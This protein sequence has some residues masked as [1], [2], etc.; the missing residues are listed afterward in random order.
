MAA[1]ASALRAGSPT[2]QARR[3][4]ARPRPS[5][6]LGRAPTRPPFLL[7]RA[8]SQRARAAD[9]R[10][11]GS[12]RLRAA[13]PPAMPRRKAQPGGLPRAGAASGGQAVLSRFFR[14]TGSLKCDS[15]PAG[16]AETADAGSTHSPSLQ[17]PLPP[18]GA[19]EIDRRKRRSSES[20]GP[21]KKKAKKLQDLEGGSDSVVSGRSEPKKCLRTRI[22]LQSLEKL[23]EFCCD[24][25]LPPHRA[26]AELPEKRFAVLPKCTDFEDISLQYKKSAV[27]LEDSSSQPNQKDAQFGPSQRSHENLQR[28]LDSRAP[29][30]RSKS[31]YTPLELQYLDVKRQHGDAVLCVECGYKYRFFGEDA[32]I[33]ARELNICCHLDHNFMTASIPTHRLFV[34]VRR[35]V[36]KGYKVG[37]V[38]Q[39]ETAALKALGDTR[40]SVF[41]R[42]LTALYTKSTLIGEDVNPL[43]QLD[44]A[45]SVDEPV[46]DTSSGF[47]LC[48]CESKESGTDG[49]SGHVLIG[50]VGVQPAT[51]EV[52]TDSFQD[53]AS[54]TELET[55]LSSLQPAELLLPTDLSQPTESLVHRTTLAGV[56]DDRIRVERM[57]NIYF[58]YSHAFQVVT[59]FYAKD[60]VDLK[61]SQSF[62]GIINLEKPVLCSLAALIRYLKEFNLEKV[63]SKPENFTQLSSEMEFMTL[64]GTTL[65]NLEILQNQTD[66]KTKGSL[67]WVLDHT[68]TSF[69]RRKLKKWVTQPLLKLR[70]I[71]AR[72][73]AVSE[74]LKS[75]ASVFGQ[76]ESQLHRL[77]DLERG[78][79]SIYHKKCST[80]EFFLVLRTLCRL[81]A[82]LGALVPAVKSLVESDLLRALLL[83][84]PEL[85]S[86]AEP[87]LQILNEPAAKIGD[88]TE[89]FKDLSDFP[90]IRK[91]KDEIQ[92]VTNKI[93]AHLQEIRGVLGSPRAQYVTV[94]GQEFLIE[95]KNSA[96]S[97]VPADWVKVSSTKAVSRFHSPFV[98]ENYRHLTQLREQLGLDCHAEWLRFL[99]NFGAHYPMLCRAVSHLATVDCLF[100]LARVAKQ[101]DYCRPVLQEEKK[102]VIK[103]GRHPVIDVLL[104]EQEQY[105]P[106]SASLSADS[107]RVMIITGPNMGGKS[108]YMRQ[109]A[110]VTIMAQIGSYVPAEQAT[111]GI[112]DGIYTRMG[113]ADNIHRGRSTFMEELTDAAEIIR[114]A[115]PRS[116]VILDELGRGTSTHDGIA[117]AYATLE[118]FIR[119]VRSLTLFVTHYPPVC[120]LE[121][122]Y[123]QQVGNYH[124]GFLVS[125]E[126]G[127]PEP[128]KEEEVP[129]CVTFLY[130]I[131]RGVAS[132][133]YGLNV[134]RLADMPEEILK[135]AARKSRELEGVVNRKRKRLKY[136]TKIWAT[137]S[138]RDLQAWAAEVEADNCGR[139]VGTRSIPPPAD[140]VWRVALLSHLRSNS[141][142]SVLEPWGQG[143]AHTI[144][145]RTLTR[146]SGR[147]LKLLWKSSGLSVLMRYNE[148]HGDCCYR[149]GVTENGRQLGGIQDTEAATPAQLLKPVRE[150]DA[151]TVA[152]TGK[153]GGR[154]CPVTPHAVTPHPGAGLEPAGHCVYMEHAQLR[155]D[156]FVALDMKMNSS[157]RK[158]QEAFS[159]WHRTLRPRERALRSWVNPVNR[160]PVHLGQLQRARTGRDSGSGS[161]GALCAATLGSEGVTPPGSPSR[162]TA[163]TGLSLEFSV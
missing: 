56:R 128:D 17:P 15:C 41:S 57:E 159:Q 110:L 66:M 96:V 81:K 76:V 60:V 38:K 35:L 112:V 150:E 9:A 97:S 95:V 131:T 79:G 61:G 109:V 42:K 127:L 22:A 158:P 54:R 68:K 36:A 104:G 88:K 147:V 146:R 75:E 63:L 44:S 84:T 117:I 12:A 145:V 92:D 10:A 5:R 126:E 140:D 143:V 115:T 89:L 13:A 83:E 111:L 70:D 73:D 141:G 134:A 31:V 155:D 77:P 45:V 26:Q 2:L 50:I 67:F 28:A 114:K 154:A 93:Q 103:N 85:L 98:A 91:R 30:R 16:A 161:A 101:G 139:G 129:A 123:P 58:E 80:Q 69:G 151:Q 43:V 7:D 19:V 40:G 99:E 86:A 11:S 125:E 163:A 135:T 14:P 116:L 8:R 156:V 132:R 47:L 1:S 20:D 37:V 3:G 137:P 106:N 39:T 6:L 148:K 157:G 52:V 74:V 144:Q 162:A 153:R 49:R 102:I 64:S 87:C 24:S 149:V 118:Y 62:S 142:P 71:N 33:A 133:S 113:A 160:V 65:R 121:K 138:A 124:M 122:R 23:K 105:V 82:E 18:A 108:S 136:F 78:L 32:E 25:A 119:D 100:S 120:E 21:L 152:E 4:T 90:L 94:S 29:N 59:E 107:E 130:Q 27:S 53:S 55:R 34:H 48:V 46:T 51:G 72:L